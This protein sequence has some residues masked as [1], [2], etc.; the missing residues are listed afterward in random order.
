[1]IMLLVLNLRLR[2]DDAD[3]DAGDD[4]DG[5]DHHHDGCYG[6]DDS[7]SVMAQRLHAISCELRRC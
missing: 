7:D 2:M 4:G 1:M 3:D 5:G 6:A